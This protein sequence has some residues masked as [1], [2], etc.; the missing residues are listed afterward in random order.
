MG[1]HKGF[2]VKVHRIFHEVVIIAFQSRLQWKILI[3]RQNKVNFGVRP[4]S[5][6]KCKGTSM[7]LGQM[8]LELVHYVSESKF[9]SST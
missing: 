2:A 8:H 3:I 7:H 1:F 9:F 5:V 4:S 6:G